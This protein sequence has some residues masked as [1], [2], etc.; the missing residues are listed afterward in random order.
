VAVSELAT[1]CAEEL[2]PARHVQTREQLVALQPDLS[3]AQTAL[4][5]LLDA[6]AD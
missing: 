4:F 6:L 1:A 2:V 3:P 5:G